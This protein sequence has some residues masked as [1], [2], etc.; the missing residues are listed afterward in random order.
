MLPLADE[1]ARHGHAPS[2][3]VQD[4][5]ATRALMGRRRYPL[6]PLPAWP[7][8]PAPVRIESW[9]DIAHNAGLASPLA[10]GQALAGWLRLLRDHSF[11]L[12]LAEAA[13]AAMLAARV[14]GIPALAFGTG[15]SVP[16]P[17]TPL[18]AIRFWQPPSAATLGAAEARLLAAIDPALAA[19][20]A[21]AT[22]TR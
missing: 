12:V 11:H 8:P 19:A 17:G 22:P 9:A 7:A 14:A 2:L 15:W 5:A 21:P 10:V 13:P 6:L 1:L 16:P 20:G 4:I 18:P 3:V